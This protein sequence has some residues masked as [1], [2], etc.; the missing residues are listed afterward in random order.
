MSKVYKVNVHND[1]EKTKKKVEVL[2]NSKSHTIIPYP[3]NQVIGI[4]F[5]TTKYITLRV[6]KEDTAP[7][8][9]TRHLDIY[10]KGETIAYRILNFKNEINLELVKRKTSFLWRIFWAIFGPEDNVSVGEHEGL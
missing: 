3:E 5:Q 9:P 8:L 1:L 4:D 6:K 10:N 7:D 2:I